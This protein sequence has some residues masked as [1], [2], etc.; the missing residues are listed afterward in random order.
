[1]MVA[2]R[3]GY[4]ASR[5]CL[6][7]ICVFSLVRLNAQAN[8]LRFQHL[9]THDGLLS[10]ITSAIVQDQKGY[11]W[12]GTYN[13]LNR[14]DGYS[15]KSFINQP[16]DS[17]SLIQ[18][19]IVALCVDNN[20]NIWAGSIYGICKYD[21]LGGRFYRTM[22]GP[23][24]RSLLGLYTPMHLVKD[25]Q[26]FIWLFNEPRHCYR[27]N[28][29]TLKYDSFTVGAGNR[30]FDLNAAGIMQSDSGVFDPGKKAFVK[31][32]TVHVRPSGNS[33]VILCE[34]TDNHNILWIG[35]NDGIYVY[36]GKTLLKRYLAGH[37]LNISSIFQ[38]RKGLVWAGTFFSGVFT[39]D[40]ASG[41]VSHYEHQRE[42]VNSISH[43]F[44]RA[45]CADNAGNI[46]IGTKNGLDKLELIARR[47]MQYPYDPAGIYGLNATQI[48]A[49]H[50]DRKG[51]I[52]VGTCGG[53]LNEINRQGEQLHF[54]AYLYQKADPDLYGINYINSIEDDKYGK[55]LVGGE[56]GLYTFDTV[57][58]KFSHVY[59]PGQKKMEQDIP[60]AVWSILPLNE[61]YT[62]IGTQDEGLY[63]WNRRTDQF[64]NAGADEH[65]SVT[66][67]GPV[68]CLLRDH[69]GNV[70]LGNNLGLFNVI[71]SDD[72][73][74][75]ALK[76][77]V[78]GNK[79][80]LEGNNVWEVY[81]DDKNRLWLA[82]TE[83]GLNVLD[84][85]THYFQHYTTK[86]GLPSNSICSI[87]QDGKDLWIGTLNG[88]CLFDPAL[89][90][91]RRSYTEEDGLQSNHLGYKL[92]LKS[93][94]GEIFI[95]SQ[96][97]LNSFHPEMLH[98]VHF[99]PQMVITSFRVF[100]RDYEDDL[101][102]PGGVQLNHDQNS[103]SL[104]FASLDLTNPSHNHFRYYLE[105]L[106][107]EW[108]YSGT[109]H[110]VNYTGVPPG[111]YTFHLQ[112]TNSEGEWSAKELIFPIY[113]KSILAG[114]VV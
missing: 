47:F 101:N 97:G 80:R 49:L 88:L 99:Q 24:W 74:A 109:R 95:G 86:N 55:L 20:D 51:N 33:S 63:L 53:G 54:H 23:R 110:I 90:K 16:D 91:A 43:N 26:G 79:T 92:L 2:Q 15:F 18:G 7:L 29:Q 52:W 98:P 37:S 40:P 71:F 82:T 60:N 5:F 108:Q 105:G 106:E 112:G 25:K 62:L 56:N 36:S 11:L 34:Y 39:I 12:I 32:D 3:I 61:H 50:E 46:W 42:D 103:F 31:V 77:Y 89:G 19:P 114:M 104:E 107:N 83:S 100:Y 35:T 1:M 102:K 65:S 13:G 9:S 8:Y 84:L 68:W 111:R 69:C 81:E 75:I 30:Y 38:D 28:P 113:R 72:S 57:T 10:N 48:R 64:I 27:I 17:N 6:M 70:W 94:S 66:Y 58:K 76:P 85:E 78:S 44:I 87:L 93:R 45:L 59:L 41:S 22:T 67:K 96:N 21:R 14:Y 4:A 73:S